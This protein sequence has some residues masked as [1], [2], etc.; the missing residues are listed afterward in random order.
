MKTYI[1]ILFILFAAIIVIL[2]LITSP[3]PVTSPETLL[4]MK[5]Y[6]T[7][8]STYQNRDEVHYKQSMN[9]EIDDPKILAFAK[10]F[11]H[12][13]SYMNKAGN[14]AS[15]KETRKIVQNHGLSVEVYTKIASRMNENPDFQNRVQEMINDVN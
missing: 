8:R 14:K 5:R 9:E 7:E 15:Y 13:Q 12:V 6:N 3:E 4:D 10:A 2:K 1:L 11:V